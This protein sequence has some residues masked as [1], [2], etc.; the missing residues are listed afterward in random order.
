MAQSLAELDRLERDKLTDSRGRT[1]KQLRRD[2]KPRFAV[3]WR[4]IALGHVALFGSCAGLV[5]LEGRYPMA[6][7]LLAIAGAFP[8]AYSIAYISLFFHEA[9]HYNLAASRQANDTLANLFVGSLTGQSIK[10]Y[11]VVHFDH[12]RLLGTHEDTERS[13]FDALNARFIFESVSGIKLVRVLFARRARVEADAKHTKQAAGAS[14]RMLVAGLLLNLSVMA[15]SALAQRWSLLFAWPFGMLVLHPAINAIRQLLEHRRY[16]ARSDVDY[17]STDQGVMTR[18]F[19]SGPLAS[20]LGG[21][22]FNRHLLHHWEPQLSYTRFRELELFLLD[23][24]AAPAVRS[25]STSYFRT[26]YTLLKAP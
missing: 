23:T 21:A 15:G 10:A 19:G 25:V 5:W 17:A 7:P 1:F 13:Y 9:A 22:G 12:H 24:E 8:I 20:T 18:M 26:F 6:W 4:D 14:R 3:V 2:L 16:E 11:R